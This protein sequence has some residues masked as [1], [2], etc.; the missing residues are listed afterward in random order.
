M[1][2][3]CLLYKGVVSGSKDQ[4]VSI[5]CKMFRDVVSLG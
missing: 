5:L 1:S 3:L 2:I 4:E